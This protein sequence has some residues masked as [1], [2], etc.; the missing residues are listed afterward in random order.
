MNILLIRPERSRQLLRTAAS[1]APLRHRI[2]APPRR[3]LTLAARYPDD[4]P[5]QLVDLGV[6]S[7]DPGA[8]STAMS[9]SDVAIVDRRFC[10]Q[11]SFQRIAQLGASST[12]DLIVPWRR[13]PSAEE[14]RSL[15]ESAPGS[16]QPAGLWPR[17]AVDTLDSWS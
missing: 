12:A 15:G 2:C 7:L 1:W 11:R 9:T 10:K 6:T 14:A 17:S 4:W 13:T 3:L 5:K 8:I 16:E